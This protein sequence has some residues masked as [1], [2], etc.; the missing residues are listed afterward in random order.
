MKGQ[1][2]ASPYGINLENNVYKLYSI[3]VHYLPMNKDQLYSD[4]K[5]Q[6]LTLVLEPGT[7]LDEQSLSER[8]S[9]SRTPLREVFRT[10]AGEGLPGYR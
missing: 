7:S 4:L 1:P 3:I 2:E 5:K 6:I 10:L 8:Y 9:I